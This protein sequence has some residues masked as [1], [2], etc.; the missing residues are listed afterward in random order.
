MST[1]EDMAEDLA[2]KA[3][4]DITDVLARHDSL[5]VDIPGFDHNISDA[6]LLSGLG[7]VAGALVATMLARRKAGVTMEQARAVLMTLLMRGL[8]G[9]LAQPSVQERIERG[10]TLNQAAARKAAH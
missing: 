3:L 7:S 2:N 6:R 5:V 4:L 9:F 1:M 8:D 10:A